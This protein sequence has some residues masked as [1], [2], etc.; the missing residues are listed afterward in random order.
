MRPRA[1]Q[2]RLPPY[3]SYVTWQK[4]IHG[5]ATFLPDIVDGSYY[6]EL[7]FSGSDSKKLRTALRFLGFVDE[8]N[9]PTQ[10]LEM[11][12]QSIR[13]ESDEGK[14]TV[15]QQV[16]RDA[17]TPLF[18]NDFSLRT[19]TLGGLSGRFEEMGAKG[20]VQRQCISFF[21]HLATEA[22]IE[23]SPHL[24]GKSRLGIGR[25]STVLKARERRRGGKDKPTR[26]PVWQR[27]AAI[28][29]DFDFSRLHPGII[30]LITMLPEAGSIWEQK[31]QWKKAFEAMIDLVYPSEGE[32]QA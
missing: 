27:E 25:K 9:V 13:Q 8:N 31:E 30:G 6:G 19:A 4:L 26:E 3:V 10:K 28:G 17:Y 16:L 11:L 24:A 22:G 18:A 7:R 29:I 14:A 23:L 12:V 5:F 32:K 2:K 21:L 15:L 1:N 20:D